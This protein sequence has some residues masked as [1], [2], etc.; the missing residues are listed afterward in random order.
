M[1]MDDGWRVQVSPQE[2]VDGRLALDSLE[3]AARSLSLHGC[4]LLEP[5]LVGAD[6]CAA[7]GACAESELRLLLRR[8]ALTFPQTD[9]LRDR[10][11]SRQLCSRSEHGRRFDA[12]IAQAAEPWRAVLERMREWTRPILAKSSI[13]GEGADAGRVYT[14]GCVTSL[15]GGVAQGFHRDGDEPGCVNVFCNLV[16]VDEENGPTELIL[17][18]HRLSR[19]EAAAAAA[20]RNG[21]RAASQPEDA[22]ATKDSV[23]ACARRGSLLLFDFRTIHRGAAHRSAPGGREGLDAPARPVLYAVAAR[24]AM[25]A[26]DFFDHPPLL[27]L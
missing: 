13:L 5:A 21:A 11:Y 25:Q 27:D 24:P 17:G 16:D 20:H 15:A 19:R 1:A 22:C 2:A 26:W 3:R 4:V 6:L 12:H 9:P 10:I 14:A 8:A 23:R 18:S 7:A